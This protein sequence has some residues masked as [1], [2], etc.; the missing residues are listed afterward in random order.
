M[1]TLHAVS[2][3]AYVF[4]HLTFTEHLLY[5]RRLSKRQ[6]NTLFGHLGVEADSKQ[7]TS[8]DYTE[9]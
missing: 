6:Q 3:L 2:S 4:I 5:V 1:E 9:L 7:D 8:I